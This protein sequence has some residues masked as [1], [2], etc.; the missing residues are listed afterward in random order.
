[1]NASRFF[2]EPIISI[3]EVCQERLEGAHAQVLVNNESTYRKLVYFR[4][5][6]AGALLYGDISGAGIFYR[7]YRDGIL[8]GVEAAVELEEKSEKWVFGPLLPA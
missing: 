3:G 6:L 8:L 7:L 2:G 5:R 1:M 4:G